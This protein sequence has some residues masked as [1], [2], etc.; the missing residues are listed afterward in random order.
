M[1]PLRL[2]YL[3]LAILGGLM[4]LWGGLHP[5]LAGAPLVG[6]AA[7]A[8]WAFSE[9]AVRRNWWAL[10]ALPVA[11]VLGLGCG[12]PL[13]LFLRLAKVDWG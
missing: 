10:T 11:A 6:L 13:Y 9:T 1:S 12:L 2:T 8:I 4:G 7:L 5:P 3:G